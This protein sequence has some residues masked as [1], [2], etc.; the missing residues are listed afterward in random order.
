MD[1]PANSGGSKSPLTQQPKPTHFPFFNLPVELQLGIL[2]CTNLVAPDSTVAWRVNQGFSLWV[3]RQR[4]IGIDFAPERPQTCDPTCGTANDQCHPAKHFDCTG[5]FMGPRSDRDSQCLCSHACDSRDGYL[6]YSGESCRCQHYICEFKP[7]DMAAHLELA[8]SRNWQTPAS[9]FLVSR[10]F[11]DICNTVF[12]SGNS[13]DLG[14]SGPWGNEMM[15]GSHT[16][17]GPAFLSQVVPTSA[18]SALKTIRVDFGHY[19][20]QERYNAK[21]LDPNTATKNRP[22][23]EKLVK[24]DPVFTEWA[25]TLERTVDQLRLGTVTLTHINLNRHPDHLGFSHQKHLDMMGDKDMTARLGQA[26]AS[27]YWPPLKNHPLSVLGETGSNRDGSQRL[28]AFLNLNTYHFVAPIYYIRR[29]LG[30]AVPMS[31]LMDH[32][33]SKYRMSSLRGTGPHR[34]SD[35]EPA[36]PEEKDTTVVHEVYFWKPR[37]Q[38]DKQF[39]TEFPF[40]DFSD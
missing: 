39:S 26:V 14:A 31:M 17:A 1:N 22:Q 38:D 18:L 36:G 4:A 8:Y 40:S 19:K 30:D 20:A 5:K 13:F 12:Y 23:R 32:L 7:P 16:L 9:L 34:V 24:T 6:I 25:Q 28:L 3:V 2:R 37:L 27:I 35:G 10:G 21:Y 11:R 15:R 33:G 29:Q